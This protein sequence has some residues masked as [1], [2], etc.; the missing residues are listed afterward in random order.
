MLYFFSGITFKLP[1]NIN[2]EYKNFRIVNF[3]FLFLQN[4]IKHFDRFVVFSFFGPAVAGKYQVLLQLVLVLDLL[5]QSFSKIYSP[6]IYNKSD[7]DLDSDYKNIYNIFLLLGVSGFILRDNLVTLILP[8]QYWSDSYLL[9]YL[10]PGSVFLALF[11][12]E[13]TKILKNEES[14]KHLNVLVFSFLIGFV[15]FIL[16]NSFIGLTSIALMFLIVNFI[17][18]IRITSLKNLFNNMFSFNNLVILFFVPIFELLM[19]N[20]GNNGEIQMRWVASIFIFNLVIVN[21]SKLFN[22]NN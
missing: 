11:K 22:Y 8:S 21:I 7:V 5:S 6:I 17:N 3:K 18:L 19:L 14:K 4:S 16:T 13:V 15:F 10:I 12:F 9:F 2:I 1:K 20:I